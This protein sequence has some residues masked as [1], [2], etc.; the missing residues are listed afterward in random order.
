MTKLIEQRLPAF[1][2]VNSFR[3]WSM[4]TAPHAPGPP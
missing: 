1:W 3:C 4:A 2:I